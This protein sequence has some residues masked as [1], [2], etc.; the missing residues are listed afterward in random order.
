MATYIN[1]YKVIYKYDVQ[2]HAIILWHVAAYMKHYQGVI[3]H[4]LGCSVTLDNV[5]KQL[6]L[7]RWYNTP[8]G[9]GGNALD[10]TV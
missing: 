3:E 7:N 4:P 1:L 10:F 8:E 2:S 6:R 9:V 5:T